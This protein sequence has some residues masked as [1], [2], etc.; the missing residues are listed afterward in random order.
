MFCDVRV[1]YKQMTV[2][3]KAMH[4]TSQLLTI[5]FVQSCLNVLERFRIMTDT[6][7]IGVVTFDFKGTRVRCFFS[8]STDY[9]ID[10]S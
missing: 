4:T 6:Q 8:G 2:A 10:Y 9:Q 3:E 5:E 7:A 1:S